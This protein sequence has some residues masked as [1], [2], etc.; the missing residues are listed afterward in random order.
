MPMLHNMS[1]PKF[2]YSEHFNDDGSVREFVIH[3]HWPRFIMEFIDGQGSPQFL[4]P[5][6]QVITLELE[7]GR[8]PAV[9]IS[10]LM[11]EASEFFSEHCL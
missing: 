3:N 1:L 4:D 6:S 2:L 9:L 7:A 11:R 8:E 10:R 5:E